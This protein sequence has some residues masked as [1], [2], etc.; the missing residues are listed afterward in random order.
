M[1]SLLYVHIFIESK[2]KAH[3]VFSLCYCESVSG[4]MVLTA[5]LIRS[6]VGNKLINLVYSLSTLSFF[7]SQLLCLLFTPRVTFE[8]L[9]QST[10]SFHPFFSYAELSLRVSPLLYFCHSVFLRDK[11][12]NNQGQQGYFSRG[13]ETRN[14]TWRL[15]I[16]T[17]F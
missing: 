7:I 4:S 10:L 11:S 16:F 17:D 1:H 5:T 15:H 3:K 14:T 12:I 6:V 9:S 2:N 8:S 13:P